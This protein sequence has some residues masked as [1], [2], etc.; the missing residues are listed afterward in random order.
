M[1]KWQNPLKSILQRLAEGLPLRGP[2]PKDFFKYESDTDAI[3]GASV[4]GDKLW[5]VTSKQ[6]LFGLPTK[7]STSA[8]P[9][10]KPIKLTDLTYVTR[11]G[12][13]P[14]GIILAADKTTIWVSF[15]ADIV[16]IDTKKNKPIDVLSSHTAPIDRMVTVG[17]EIWSMSID[18]QLRVWEIVRFAIFLHSFCCLY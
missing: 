13:F 4:V 18:G 17:D 14:R 5:V 16:R 8:S 10:P 11:A 7:P 12:F 15:D 6:E 1:N 2:E 9:P 3:I